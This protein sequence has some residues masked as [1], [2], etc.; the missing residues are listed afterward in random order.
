M[1]IPEKSRLPGCKPP[2]SVKRERYSP[3]LRVPVIEN[4]CT[5]GPFHRILRVLMQIATSRVER[6]GREGQLLD[7]IV[8]FALFALFCVTQP[9]R[10]DIR[11]NEPLMDHFS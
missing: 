9:S 3:P 10:G 8:P 2:E 11:C 5:S 7:G 6:E 4:R 1:G